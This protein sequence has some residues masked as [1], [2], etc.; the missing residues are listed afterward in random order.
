MYALTEKGVA[1]AWSVM[2]SEELDEILVTRI[3]MVDNWRAA[4]ELEASQGQHEKQELESEQEEVDED[5]MDNINNV[6]IDDDDETLVGPD[7]DDEDWDNAEW[8][9]GRA[10][11]RRKLGRDGQSVGLGDELLGGGED[12]E[13]NEGLRI[14]TGLAREKRMARLNDGIVDGAI[15]DGRLGMGY[16]DVDELTHRKIE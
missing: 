15:V 7:T 6:F 13:K 10:R 8:M 16:V 9:E 3:K 4:H 5:D 1:K 12:A 2:A 14:K 11:K